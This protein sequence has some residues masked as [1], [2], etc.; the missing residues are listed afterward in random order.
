MNAK[1]ARKPAGNTI[2]VNRRARH[3]YFIEETLEAGLALE[4]W[5]AKSL[6]EGRAQLAE[7]YVTPVS[8]THLTLPTN[9]NA[10][11]S[12]WSPYH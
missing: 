12:R 7:A 4:G 3:D 5:E 8:Y 11:R 1:K 10:C 9:T 6:R 2:A